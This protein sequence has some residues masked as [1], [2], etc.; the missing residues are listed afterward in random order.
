MMEWN[1]DLLSAYLDGELPAET[2]A[3]IE[4]Q[5]AR[6]A[7]L[8]QRLDQLRRVDQRLRAALPLPELAADDPLAALIRQSPQTRHGM[9]GGRLP[10]PQPRRLLSRHR[11]PVFALAASLFGVAVGHVIT[12]GS[13]NEAAPPGMALSSA[14]ASA[15]E[16]KPSGSRLTRDGETAAVLLSFKADDGRYCRAFDW[17][18]AGKAAAGLACRESGTWQLVAWQATAAASA[19]DYRPASGGNAAVDAAIEALG[20]SDALDVGAEQ[21]LIARRWH[22]P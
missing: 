4:A 17:Q 15:L 11:A 18:A 16:Q 7:R 8:R 3:A 12:R 2:C 10:T 21:Q 13:N 6:D 9:Q 19:A 20:G 22:Q 5:C 14:L 1:D